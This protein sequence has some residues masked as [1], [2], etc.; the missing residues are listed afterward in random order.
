M[1][2]CAGPG[3]AVSF[4]WTNIPIAHILKGMKPTAEQKGNIAMRQKIGR[5]CMVLGALLTAL[6]VWRGEAETVLQK[7]VMI[8]MEC[9]GIG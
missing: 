3:S 2:P 4:Y 7:A 5:V 6:G 1:P 8:C 9:I